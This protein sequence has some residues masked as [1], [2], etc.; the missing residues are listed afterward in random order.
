MITIN[1]PLILY[2]AGGYFKKNFIRENTLA[3]IFSRGQ[4]GFRKVL[5]PSKK[6]PKWPIMCVARI[7]K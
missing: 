7:K 3:A 4:F 5:A 1:V 2:S 6:P